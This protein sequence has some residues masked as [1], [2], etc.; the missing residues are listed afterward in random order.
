MKQF[1]LLLFFIP[2]IAMSQGKLKKA[3][4]SLKEKSTSESST[5]GTRNVRTSSG[6]SSS[7]DS[8]IENPFN[9]LLLEIGFH[10]TLGIAVGQAQERDLNPY[11]YFYDNEGEYAA[12]LSDTGRKQS[13]K[14][15]ANY[16]F[17]NINGFEFNANYK[18]IPIIGIDASY[19]HFSE[20]N[21]MGSDALDIVSLMVNYHRFREKN[22]TV[23][24]GAGV[25]YVAN[26]V[27]KAGFAYNLGTEIYPFK[28]ISLHLSWKESFINESEIGVFKSQLKYH[29]KDKAFF[30]GYQH[31][32]IG[33]ERISAPTVGFEII[34]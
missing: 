4:N 22:F 14:L 19:I 27:D 32:Q 23:W 20:K 13:L 2:C 17:N 25:T 28:P 18:P 10:A 12:E 11:P 9:N 31:Y 16:L 33:S 34:F 29:I 3:K 15:G 24:W 1:L 6:G 5:K 21:R 30:V 26:E 7:N 8:G